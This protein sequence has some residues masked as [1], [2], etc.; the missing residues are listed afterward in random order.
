MTNPIKELNSSSVITEPKTEIK[1]EREIAALARLI[2][3]KYRETVVEMHKA[4]KT[5]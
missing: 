2:S 4:S 3:S 5:N 1:S